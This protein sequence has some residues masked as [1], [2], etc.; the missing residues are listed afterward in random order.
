MIE[1]LNNYIKT[2]HDMFEELTNYGGRSEYIE[3]AADLID[4][5]ETNLVYEREIRDSRR[6][7]RKGSDKNDKLHR[8]K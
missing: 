2:L 1:L 8:C 3:R 4:E 5:A 6:S 7:R